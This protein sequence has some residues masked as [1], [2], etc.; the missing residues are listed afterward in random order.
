[1]CRCKNS[2][3]INMTNDLYSSS[4]VAL[5]VSCEADCQSWLLTV[6]FVDA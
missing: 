4:S 5:N 1:M 3:F 6:Q 2:Y